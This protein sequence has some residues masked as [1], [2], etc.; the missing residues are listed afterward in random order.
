[1]A[2]VRCQ[3]CGNMISNKAEACIY[4][5]C[6]LS[7]QHHDCKLVIQPTGEYTTGLLYAVKG[8][9]R[10]YIPLYA[11]G[12]NLTCIIQTGKKY[13]VC[14]KSQIGK[15]YKEWFFTVEPYYYGVVAS[16]TVEHHPEWLN[17]R[18]LPLFIYHCAFK[19]FENGI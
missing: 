5:G 2:M 1:M 3:E 16:V 4:C 12:P 14:C 11:E 6:P 19:Y 8:E 15:D 9:G 10:Q 18:E 13:G 17:D 7:M